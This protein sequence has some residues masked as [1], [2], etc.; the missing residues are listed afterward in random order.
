MTERGLR[1]ALLAV[2]F[3]TPRRC[4]IAKRR[5]PPWG[6][7]PAAIDDWVGPVQM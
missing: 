2:R 1:G 4:R 5:L 7:Q 6:P 3:G